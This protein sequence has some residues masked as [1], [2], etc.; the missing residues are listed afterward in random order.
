M[1]H[2]AAVEYGR[3]EVTRGV[4]VEHQATGHRG[5]RDGMASRRY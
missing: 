2:A 4:L 1:T 3:G 5:F